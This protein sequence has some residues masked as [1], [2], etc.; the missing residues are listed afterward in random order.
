MKT[1][2]RILLI[3]VAVPVVLAAGGFIWLMW[4]IEPE[5]GSNPTRP[6]D[7]ARIACKS[8]L[9]TVLN[10]PGSAEWGITS[11]GAWVAWPVQ[12]GDDG[13]LVVLPAFRATNGFGAKVLASF[14]CETR[15]VDG[16][17][18]VTDLVQS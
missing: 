16:R 5:G 3:V 4:S 11:Q 8:A 13:R 2:F 7:L 12:Q 1:F 6:Q 9:T 14:R 17:W 15:E 18:V 10:D